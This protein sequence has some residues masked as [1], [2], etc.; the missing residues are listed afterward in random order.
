[1]ELA[2]R[3]LER[4]FTDAQAKLKAVWENPN[5]ANICSEMPNMNILMAN[6][7]AAMNRTRL[8]QKDL[9]LLRR[10]AVETRSS[11]CAGCAPICESAV[12]EDAPIADVLRYLMYARSY[13]DTGRAARH[14]NRIPEYKRHNMAELD[15]AM[16]EKRCPQKMAIGQLI[17]ECMDELS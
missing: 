7:S 14:F 4:G 9:D 5:I 16:A 8:S 3:F 13:G 11:Y 12:E 15:Y 1:M 6:V 2:G 10:H 17:R